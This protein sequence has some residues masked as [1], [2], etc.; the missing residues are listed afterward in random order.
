RKLGRATTFDIVHA[1]N[2]PDA[3][4]LTSWPLR[5]RGAAVVFDQHDLVPELYVSRFG[6]HGPLH[7]ATLVAERLA[8]HLADVV[9]STNESYR[10]VALERGRKS[11]KD[12]F[13]VRSAPDAERFRAVRPDD[14][15]RRG[16]R[17]LLA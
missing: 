13:V 7:R 12:V 9:L 10:R 17:H 4:I 2:P 1:C 16:K 15:L 6:R 8:F 3:L 14:S 11:P 5:R